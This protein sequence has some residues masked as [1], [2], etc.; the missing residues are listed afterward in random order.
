[1]EKE[2]KK[3]QPG[4]ADPSPDERCVFRKSKDDFSFD[5]PQIQLG[6]RG[7]S[8]QRLVR[9]AHDLFVDFGPGPQYPEGGSDMSYPEIAAHTIARTWIEKDEANVH[10]LDQWQHNGNTY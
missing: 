5:C 3:D 7:T 2:P 10:F 4:D 8:N 9:L 6:K 1:M